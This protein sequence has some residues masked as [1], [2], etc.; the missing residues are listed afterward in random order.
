MVN[1]PTAGL[2]LGSQSVGWDRE[3]PWSCRWAWPNQGEE[4]ARVSTQVKRG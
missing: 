1:R 2:C 4:S 3:H